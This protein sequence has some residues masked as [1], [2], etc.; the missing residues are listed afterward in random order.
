MGQQGSALGWRHAEKLVVADSIGQLIVQPTIGQTA[1]DVRA[2]QIREDAA[3]RIERLR[4]VRHVLLAAIICVTVLLALWSPVIAAVFAILGSV[5]LAY[6]SRVQVLAGRIATGGM[7]A[8]AIGL[9]A[10]NVA[11]SA[12]PLRGLVIPTLLILVILVVDEV[13]SEPDPEPRPQPLPAPATASALTA[14]NPSG[15]NIANPPTQPDGGTRKRRT[16]PP[17]KNR[18]STPEEEAIWSEFALALELELL[19]CDGGPAGVSGQG[20]YYAR[21][22]SLSCFECPGHGIVSKL[23]DA[24]TNVPPALAKCYDQAVD[25]LLYKYVFPMPPGVEILDDRFVHAAR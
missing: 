24:E 9:T 2:V 3:V 14:P 20:V 13:W 18:P 5:V 11:A 15:S 25:G 8:Q 1:E 19:G 16:E 17:L 21:E 22:F 4:T 23:A 12:A 7:S 6:L 10:A